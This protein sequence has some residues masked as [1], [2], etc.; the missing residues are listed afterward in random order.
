MRIKKHHIAVV[1][2]VCFL[3][4]V[5][6]AAKLCGKISSETKWQGGVF[7]VIN[8]SGQTIATTP[9]IIV[10]SQGCTDSFS[11]GT[12]LIRFNGGLENTKMN[13]SDEIYG[14]LTAPY[15]FDDT[16]LSVV[17]NQGFP[18]FNGNSFCYPAS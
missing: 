14:C 8:S 6:F 7:S 10:G 3:N 1:V 11:P 4:Q 9:Y 2:A 18:P 5:S 12:Y 17:F 13:F 16:V 15:V